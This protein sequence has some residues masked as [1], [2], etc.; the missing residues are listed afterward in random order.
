MERILEEI[1]KLRHETKVGF[2]EIDNRLAQVSDGLKD[3]R[4]QMSKMAT[5]MDGGFDIIFKFVKDV[6]EKQE[7]RLQKIE[8]RLDKAGL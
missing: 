3:T 1:G 6:Q 7:T 2:L 4:S 5:L 8:E